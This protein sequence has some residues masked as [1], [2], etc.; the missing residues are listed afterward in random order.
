M[1]TVL[2]NQK[3]PQKKC[4]CGRNDIYTGDNAK[5]NPK[6]DGVDVCEDCFVED[7]VNKYHNKTD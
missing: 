1:A 7:F 3:R 6:I 5:H 2:K 4:R